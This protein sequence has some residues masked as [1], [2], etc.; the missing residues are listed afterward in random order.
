MPEA[1]ITR[2]LKTEKEV[3][4]EI[5]NINLNEALKE[6][7]KHNVLLKED[8]HLIVRQIPKWYVDKAVSITGELKFPGVYTFHKGERLSSVLERAG[9]LT[10]EAYLPGAFFT[11]ESVRKAQ[12]K[13][14]QDFIEEQEQEIMKE[15]ARA[16]EAAISKEEAEQRQKAMAQRRELTARLKAAAA[17]GRVVIKLSPLDKFKG[18]EYDLELEDGDSLYV[19]MTPSS[20][21]VMGRVYNPNAIIYSK[22]KP[23]EYYLNKVGGPGE[24][25]DEKRIYLV[26]A[27]GSVLSRTQSGSWGFRWDG[28]SHR[29]THGGF[30]A[31]RMD[32]GDTILVPEKYERIFW[33]KEL[34][35]WTQ[36]IFQI[37][38][39]AGV[40]VAI[41]K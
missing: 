39:A 13:R 32:P 24:N 8:D 5:L 35:D 18:S 15:A 1:E 40:I 20:V 34:K 23:L 9:G 29:W 30:M 21:M 28:E 11:R 4:S 12:Q 10:P 31:S 22:D 14:I 19:P 27:D 38:M 26:K 33:A 7:P 3:S 17:T 6:N 37:A 16:T 41:A 36:I 2:L 25:A